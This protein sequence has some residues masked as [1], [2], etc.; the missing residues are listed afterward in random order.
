[1]AI[2]KCKQFEDVPKDDV[3]LPTFIRT[4]KEKVMDED[5]TEMEINTLNNEMEK[6]IIAERKRTEYHDYLIT[7][8]NLSAPQDSNNNERENEQEY[9]KVHPCSIGHLKNDKTHAIGGENEYTTYCTICNFC[10]RHRH[11][12]GM[13]YT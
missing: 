5:Y 1:M 7:S 2:I 9:P 13:R 4:L 10:E 6:G 8:M 12:K 11:N 3:H